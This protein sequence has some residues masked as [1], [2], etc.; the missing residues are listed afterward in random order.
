MLFSCIL[1]ASCFQLIEIFSLRIPRPA[2]SALNWIAPFGIVNTY[3]LF[4]VMTTSRPEI[5]VEGSNDAHTWLEY[6]FKYKPGDPK[7]PPRWVQ[8]HQPRLDWQMWFAALGNYQ[9]QPW[10]VNF[11]ARL[12]EG[13]PE[14]LSLIA[15]NPFPS[16]PPQYVR[17]QLYDYQFTSF[18]ER[19][20]TGNW[21]RRELKGEYFPVVSLKQR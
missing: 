1:L 9:G 2:A 8:P 17:A 13:S 6:G 3:G 18:A 11:M 5:V 21:W 7:R 12:L 15:T 10:F 20:S 14:V 16:S 4:A 19:R